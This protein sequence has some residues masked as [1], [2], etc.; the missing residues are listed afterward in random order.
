MRVC[1]W[2]DQYRDDEL[3]AEQHR[4]F[5]AHLEGCSDC[6]ARTA[7]LDNLVRALNLSSTEVPIGFAERVARRAF[8]QP[9]SWDALVVS[10]L[11]PAP[12]LVA[13]VA[14]LVILSSMWLIRSSRHVETAAYGEYEALV[15][16]SYSLN[17]G[18]SGQV[19]GDDELIGWLEQEGNTR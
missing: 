2:F 17:P 3:N 4:Q 11:R 8:H 9:K 7:L 14:M 18:A 12:T 15:N 13:L 1:E 6:R 19:H 16:E 10:W 5:E